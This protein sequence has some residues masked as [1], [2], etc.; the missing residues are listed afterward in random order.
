MGMQP[1]NTA[2][3]PPPAP[4]N[5][6]VFLDGKVVGYLESNRGKEVVR[7]SVSRK[8]LWLQQPLLWCSN[9]GLSYLQS[10]AHA[11]AFTALCPALL[12]ASQ[13]F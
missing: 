5:L 9:H 1:A 11:C 4:G 8:Q 6:T 3:P 7:R 10:K 2:L 13:S 12:S